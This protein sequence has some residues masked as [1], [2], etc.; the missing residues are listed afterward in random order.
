[1]ILY[2]LYLGNPLKD[3]QWSVLNTDI[4]IRMYHNVYFNVYFCEVG[5]VFWDDIAHVINFLS[6]SLHK[7]S[8]EIS[9]NES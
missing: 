7:L 6:C 5:K 1:M 2:W 3:K 9:L 8:F 4:L